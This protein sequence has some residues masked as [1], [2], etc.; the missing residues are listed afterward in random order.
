MQW[1]PWY[2]VITIYGN[3]I[4]MLLLDYYRS[5]AVCTKCLDVPVS[6]IIAALLILLTLYG[7]IRKGISVSQLTQVTLCVQ[8]INYPCN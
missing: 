7:L 4:V 5:S 3:I 2:D 8:L 6:L 1:E